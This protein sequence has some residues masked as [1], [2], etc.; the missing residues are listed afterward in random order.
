MQKEWINIKETG[1]LYL[2]KILVS[3]NIPILFVCHNS[4]DKKYLCLN[5]NDETGETIIDFYCYENEEIISKK[6][7]AKILSEDKLPQKGEYFDFYSIEIDKYLS[8][9]KNT[10]KDIDAFIQ[11]NKMIIKQNNNLFN[12]TIKD[13]I[14]ISYKKMIISDTLK[15]CFYETTDK[16]MIA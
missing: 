2:E 3:L 13:I 10:F 9:L 16:K 14:K 8:C 7:N 1:Q 15:K 11:N 6:E 12:V 4:K 5:I